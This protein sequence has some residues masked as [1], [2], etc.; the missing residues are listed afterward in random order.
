MATGRVW[1]WIIENCMENLAK[2]KKK[3]KGKKCG[4][5]GLFIIWCLFSSGHMGGIYFLSLLHLESYDY[6][7]PVGLS[8]TH[9]WKF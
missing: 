3:R 4:R 1:G 7:W 5:E 8:R 6:F 2:K 9:M